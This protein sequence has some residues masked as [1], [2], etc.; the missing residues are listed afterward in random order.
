[1]SDESGLLKYYLHK[2]ETKI[3]MPKIPDKHDRRTRKIRR[4]AMHVFDS[5]DGNHSSIY[6]E[7]KSVES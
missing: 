2:V 7:K 4:Q 6:D 3:G 5:A 1:M